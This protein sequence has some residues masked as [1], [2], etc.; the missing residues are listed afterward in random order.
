LGSRGGQSPKLRIIQEHNS[1]TPSNHH[2]RS[3]EIEPEQTPIDTDFEARVA[4]VDALARVVQMNPNDRSSQTIGDEYARLGASAGDKGYYD[5]CHQLLD[6]AHKY[7]AGQTLRPW[8]HIARANCFG[9]QARLVEDPE[10]RSVLRQLARLQY[11]EAARINPALPEPQ[12]GERWLDDEIE[13]DLAA[14]QAAAEEPTEQSEQT[15]ADPA[16]T[17]EDPT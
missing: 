14:Q 15:E 2:Q 11:K 17:T 4:K 1:N 13:R 10:K 12:Q 9:M 16:E 7:G 6:L 3:K 8:H 5:R